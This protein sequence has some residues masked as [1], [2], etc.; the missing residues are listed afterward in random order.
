MNPSADIF[1]ALATLPD[2]TPAQRAADKRSA[3]ILR[4]SEALRERDAS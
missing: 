3:A 2:R 1:E 4:D